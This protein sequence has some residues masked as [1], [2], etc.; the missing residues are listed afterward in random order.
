MVKFSIIA[1]MFLCSGFGVD[2]FVTPQQHPLVIRERLHFALS[3][4]SK[5]KKKTEVETFRKPDFVASI[6]AK[7]GMT[8]VDSEAALSAV[9]STITEEV[10]AGKK[11]SL[12]GFGSFKLNHRSER[13]G[14]NPRT[15]EEIKIKASS[16]PSFTASKAFKDLVNNR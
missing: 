1:A 5:T 16:T 13:M 10:A 8:K 2:G 7:T 4:E 9:L 11:I 3:A 6:A 15:G 14:R 12:L